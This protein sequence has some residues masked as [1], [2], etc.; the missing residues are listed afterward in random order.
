M[1]GACHAPINAIDQWTIDAEGNKKQN[2]GLIYDRSFISLHSGKAV[3]GHVYHKGL[4]TLIYVFMF[5]R[6]VYMINIMHAVYHSTP[7]ST[8]ILMCKYN[9]EAACMRI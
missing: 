7:I 4:E 2:Q 8:P 6:V 1:K 3:N 5:L 9:L